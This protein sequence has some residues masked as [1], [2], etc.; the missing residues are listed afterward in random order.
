M[1]S[2]GGFF[3]DLFS[4]RALMIACLVLIGSFLQAGESAANK[5]AKALDAMFDSEWDYT[6]EQNPT[7]ASQLGDRRWND[8]WGDTSLAAIEKRNQHARELLRRLKKI[9][10]RRLSPKDQLNY[11]LFEEQCET[12]IEEHQY[13]LYLVPLDHRSGI[14]TVDELASA[15]RFETVKDY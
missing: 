9:D 3:N 12:D 10:R 8:R 13:H 4:G 6:M 2:P 15:L 11:D 7:W 14:Q 5:S 1:P